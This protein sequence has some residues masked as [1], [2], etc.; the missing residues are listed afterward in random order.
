MKTEQGVNCYG[1]WGGI[2]ANPTQRKMSTET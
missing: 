2:L 1:D